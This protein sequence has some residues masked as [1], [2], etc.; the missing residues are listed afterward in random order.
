MRKNFHQDKR[1]GII[2]SYAGWFGDYVTWERFLCIWEKKLSNQ[3][4]NPIS[5]ISWFCELTDFLN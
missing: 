2:K 3:E 4:L 1:N 5:K